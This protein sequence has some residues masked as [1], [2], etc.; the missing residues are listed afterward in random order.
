L[1]PKFKILMGQQFQCV[2]N[3]LEIHFPTFSHK[4]KF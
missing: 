4:C 1:S 2:S 3:V